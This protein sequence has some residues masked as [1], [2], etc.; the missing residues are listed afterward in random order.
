M[1]RTNMV[2]E[3]P[4]PGPPQALQWPPLPVQP[5]KTVPLGRYGSYAFGRFRLSAD[6]T[7]LVRDGVRVAL[8]PKVLQTLLVLVEHAGQVVRKADLLTTIWPDS[9]VEETGLSRNVSLLRQALADEAQT[10]IVTVARIGYRF[11][12]PVVL[13]PARPSLRRGDGTRSR[14]L[15]RRKRR[16]RQL[17][18]RQ[19]P[20][21]HREA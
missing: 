19:P 11:A 1:R 17:D 3:G 4:L 16:G 20:G 13:L 10:T 15:P 14:R 8:A 18:N 2:A 5:V 21:P 7:L 12:A 6:G 9:F